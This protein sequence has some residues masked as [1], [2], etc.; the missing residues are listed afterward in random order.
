MPRNIY[1]RG[2][3]AA[4]FIGVWILCGYWAALDAN[5]YLLLGVPLLVLF[6]RYVA[7]RPLAA[8]WVRGAVRVRLSRRAIAIAAL[9][10]IAPGYALFHDAVPAGAVVVA[11][12]LAC[13]IAGAIGVGF[14]V[15]RQRA[16][17]F[18]RALPYVLYALLAGVT[19]ITM[20]TWSLPATSMSI[21]SRSLAF[22]VGFLNYLPVC[23]VLEEVVFRGALDAHV[24]GETDDVNGS[25]TQ[26]SMRSWAS[27]LFVAALWGLWHLPIAGAGPVAPTVV[28]LLAVHVPVGALLAFACRSGGTL[29]LPALAHALIDA[30][31]NALLLQ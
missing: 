30:C 1:R 9:L 15:Q 18:R 25:A 5:Q 22:V 31:R 27:A 16:D 26:P 19:I 6:Q 8:L 20:A 14:A 4:A 7:R 24:A 29:L 17:S 28:Q 11:M 10:T 3:E 12:W 23:F 21:A 13:A 2:L